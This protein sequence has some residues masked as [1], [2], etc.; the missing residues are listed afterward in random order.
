MVTS[1]LLPRDLAVCVGP[2]FNAQRA[3]T[4][5]GTRTVGKESVYM[6]NPGGLLRLLVSTSIRVHTL[7]YLQ[8]GVLCRGQM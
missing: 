8:T 3:H 7:A 1:L 5:A 6:R 2:E 4:R